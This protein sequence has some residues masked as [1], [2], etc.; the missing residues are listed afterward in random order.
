MDTGLCVGDPCAGVTCT[1]PPSGCHSSIG[2]CA[3]GVCSYG[4]KQAGAACDDGDVCTSADACTAA[5]LC[6]GAAKVCGS[7]PAP[8]CLD[9]KTSRSAAPMGACKPD[10]TCD[11]VTSDTPCA[12]GCDAATGLCSS[13]QCAAVTCNQP[14]SPCH[15][16]MGTCMAGQCTYPLLQPGAACNDGN[17]CTVNDACNANGDCAGVAKAC[18]TPPDPECASAKE[19]QSSSPTG[20][21]SPIDGS[22]GY[23]TTT[24]K[25]AVSCDL[26]TGLCLDDPCAG[27]VCNKPP[28]ACHLAVGQCTKGLC[29]YSPQPTGT[30][31]DDGDSCTTG[32][33]CDAQGSCKGAATP[34][35][36]A[37]G[38]A[39]AAGKGGAAGGGGAAGKGGAS[40]GGA[41]GSLQGGAAGKGGAGASGKSGAG[42]SGK[43]G[44]GSSQGGADGSQ[45]GDGGATDEVP[46]P[47]GASAPGC[48]C[49]VPGQDTRAP[50]ALGALALGLVAGLRR[51]RRRAVTSRSGR[52][53]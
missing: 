14:P 22:C 5:G 37:A 11:Y 32:D 29:S 27:V 2:S 18:N 21:C 8:V 40:A 10:G 47:S 43:G 42:S 13:D 25:C 12:L 44:A 16:P 9:A 48:G 24:T 3:N 20:T 17:P 28:N 53:S 41:A 6:Q 50:S 35:C 19:S 51:A 39:G 31:C 1:T 15:A 4:L 46:A 30:G 7:P 26:K 49:A 36:G 38:S 23:D 52:S 33:A 34:G 45:G